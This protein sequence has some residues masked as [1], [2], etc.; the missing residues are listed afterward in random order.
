MFHHSHPLEPFQHI[1]TV[2]IFNII[3]LIITHVSLCSS[4]PVLVLSPFI[5]LS[6]VVVSVGVN[7]AIGQSKQDEAKKTIVWLITQVVN[8]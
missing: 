6:K 2:I 7:E 3:D 1:F 4:S 5:L 8:S